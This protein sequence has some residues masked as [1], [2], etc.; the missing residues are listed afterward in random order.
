MQIVD[1]FFTADSPENS[2]RVGVLAA[3]SPENS[4]VW[5]GGR[6]GDKKALPT[7]PTRHFK[8]QRLMRESS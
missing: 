5:Q 6:F 3:D 1:P 8:D 4:S 2:G 7:V